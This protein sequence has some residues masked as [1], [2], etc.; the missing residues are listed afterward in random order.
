[1]AESM[2]RDISQY[3]KDGF[4]CISTFACFLGKDY[5]NLYGRVDIGDFAKALEE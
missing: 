1:M 4:D 3:R 5:E 2:L